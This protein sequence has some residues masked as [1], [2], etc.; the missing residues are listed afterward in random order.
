M[1]D[2]KSTVNRIQKLPTD[3][4]LGFLSEA[5]AI[6]S[7]LAGVFD[8]LGVDIQFMFSLNLIVR[9]QQSVAHYSHHQSLNR[10]SPYLGET[11]LQSSWSWPRNRWA[12]DGSWSHKFSSSQVII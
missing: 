4:G 3:H 6:Y 1:P 10:E 2:P 9:L 8:A 7:E 11:K 5:G 12:S